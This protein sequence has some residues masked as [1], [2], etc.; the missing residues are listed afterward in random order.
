M[1]L[2]EK[3]EKK[4]RGLLGEDCD[5]YF[6]SFGEGYGQTCRVN[7]LKVQ[8]AELLRRFS[9]SPVPWCETGFYYKGENRLSLHPFYYGGAYYI[10]EPCA[11]APASFL[12]VKPGDRVLDLCAAP[13]GKT[14]ALAAKMQGEGILIAN[15]ISISRCRALLKNMEM[16]GIKNAV[17]TCESPEHLSQRFAGYFDCILVDAP[18]SGDVPER[19]FHGGRL[20]AG[21]STA[22]QHSSKRDCARGGPHGSPGRISAVFYLH[23]L[24]GGE[25]T[26]GGDAAGVRKRY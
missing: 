17:I 22:L 4:M 7:Q 8:P 23:L 14:T 1:H 19:T 24:S 13:G 21:G 5:N 11:M 2:P 6:D 18:C 25:R 15:D 9:V 12:P 3:F 10:Q 16:A 20:V 26:G